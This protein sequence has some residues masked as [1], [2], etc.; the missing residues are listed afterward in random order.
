MIASRSLALPCCQKHAGSKEKFSS[1]DRNAQKL[2]RT[3]D[4]GFLGK[5]GLSLPIF[6][7][8]S[9]KNVAYNL[10]LC[11]P[12]DKYTCVSVYVRTNNVWALHTIII[13]A[14]SELSQSGAAL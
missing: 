8:V 1:G 3:S 4:R 2:I 5:D 10:R 9:M 14:I 13:N 11:S 12:L 6:S 7:Q